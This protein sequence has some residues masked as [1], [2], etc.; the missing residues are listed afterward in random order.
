M[1]PDATG[2]F[3]FYRLKNEIIFKENKQQINW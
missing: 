1:W 3:M 2:N